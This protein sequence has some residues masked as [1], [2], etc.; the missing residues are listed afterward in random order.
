MEKHVIKFYEYVNNFSSHATPLPL[1]LE[2]K[3]WIIFNLFI[4]FSEEKQKGWLES[5]VFMEVDGE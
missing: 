2:S 3:V 5:T 1:K 4:W